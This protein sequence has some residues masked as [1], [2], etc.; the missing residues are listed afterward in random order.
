MNGRDYPDSGILFKSTKTSETDRDYSGTLDSDC[1][2]CGVRT[3]WWL[4]GWK[5]MGR[6]GPFLSLKLKA[7]D[8]DARERANAAD[9]GDIPDFS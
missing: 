4:S 3:A 2:S 7:K 8:A 6:K 9:D 5:K 1:P